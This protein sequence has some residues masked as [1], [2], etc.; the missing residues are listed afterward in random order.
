[1]RRARD[2]GVGQH[3]H[4]PQ[5]RHRINQDLLP[6]AI[7]LRG[8]KTDP[9]SVA[10]RARQGGYKPFAN[11]SSVMPMRGIVRVNCCNARV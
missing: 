11:Q 8:E 10:T 9:R 4:S 1:M 6:L 3:C 5:S 7:E 2:V